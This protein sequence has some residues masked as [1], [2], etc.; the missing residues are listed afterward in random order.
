MKEWVSPAMTEL[1][2]EEGIRFWDGSKWIY[3]EEC[4]NCISQNYLDE[5]H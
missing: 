4:N 2:I 3:F 1:N 5:D